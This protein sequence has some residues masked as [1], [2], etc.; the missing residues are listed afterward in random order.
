MKKN[1][2]ITVLVLVIAVLGFFLWK[3]K[4]QPTLTTQQANVTTIESTNAYALMSAL[5][6]KFNFPITDIHSGILVQSPAEVKDYPGYQVFLGKI[7]TQLNGEI[8]NDL[9]QRG[10]TQTYATDGTMVGAIGYSKENIACSFYMQPLNAE[11]W[12]NEQSND[13]HAETVTFTCADKK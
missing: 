3:N 2:F 12:E 10:F 6:E 8:R 7:P 5:A 13:Y 4:T 11:A 9:L 1:I